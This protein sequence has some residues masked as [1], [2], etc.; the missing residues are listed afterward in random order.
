MGSVIEPFERAMA[1]SHKLS[2]VLFLTIQS[3]FDF[4]YLR[5]L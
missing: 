4:E 5:C 3:H 1:V 2:I